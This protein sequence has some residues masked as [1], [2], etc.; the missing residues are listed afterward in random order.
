MRKTADYS[1]KPCKSCQSVFK[2]ASSSSKYCSI[3]CRF[4]AHV[5]IGKKDECWNW[6]RAVTPT[7]GYGNMTVI[8]GAQ[9]PSHRVAYSLSV[10]VIPDGLFVCHKCDNR[11]CCNP[12]HLFLGSPRDNVTDMWVKRRQ[13]NY[14]TMQKGEA[15]HN[16][17]LDPSKVLYI[18]ENYGKKSANALAKELG[19]H[20]TTVISAATSKT[21]KHVMRT[22]EA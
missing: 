4:W 16:S 8:T 1:E 17:K 7:T 5:D 3:D 15:R 20:I 6:I 12:S 9:E 14:T 10:G 11:K 2:P 22:G 13:H 18:R 19:V 21:W